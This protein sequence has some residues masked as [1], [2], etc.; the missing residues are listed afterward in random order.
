MYYNISIFLNIKMLVSNA[1]IVTI[2]W[3][4]IFL[5]AKQY[6]LFFNLNSKT[7]L[8]VHIRNIYNNFSI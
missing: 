4:E 8:K 3:S 5:V 7:V 6:F 1:L 2:R